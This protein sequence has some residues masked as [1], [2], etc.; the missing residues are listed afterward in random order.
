MI[1]TLSVLI[2]THNRAE[3]LRRALQSLHAA[4]RPEGWEVR[5]L[6]AANACSDS[7]HDLLAL[8]KQARLENSTLLT[9]DWFVEP[10]A[11]K[12]FALNAAIPRLRSSDMVTF[13]DDD[14]RVD[15]GY[16]VEICRAADN[17]PHA[18]MFCGRIFP[19]WSGAEPNWVHDEGPYRIRPLP[20]PLS[21]GGP[22]PREITAEDAALPGGG[23]LFLRGEVLI[24]VGGFPTE[25]G[26]HGHD[27]GGGE[28]SIFIE[29]ALFGGERLMYIPGVLQHHYVDPERL[30]FSYTL[31][32]AYQRARTS[33][34]NKH[35]GTGIPHYQWR[36]LGQYLL[37]LAFPLSRSR[38]RFYLVRVATT[39]GE[40]AG[41]KAAK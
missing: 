30:K 12:S 27:L 8:E 34:I 33:V 29:R 25:V 36:K 13:V 17:Y 1:R 10:H 39:L 3:L 9:L 14:H 41:Q 21:D 35:V 4:R 40:M 7:T 2:C 15:A 16:L 38:L 5:I 19:E 18:T 24:R 32:K 23:N 22:D 26:P 6:V 31:R 11:G 28:D 37:A 20:V